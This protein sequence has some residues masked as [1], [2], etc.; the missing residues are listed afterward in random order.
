MVNLISSLG[1]VAVAVVGLI[2]LAGSLSMMDSMISSWSI[3]F[4][5]DIVAPFKKV[6]S[7]GMITISRI[8]AVVLGFGGLLFAMTDLPSIF[9]IISR[10][11]QGIVQFLPAVLLGLFWKRGNKASAIGGLA[12]GFIITGIFAFTA[13][14]YVPALAGMQGGLVGLVANFLV[15]T[16]FALL[17]KPK[18]ATVEFIASTIVEDEQISNIIEGTN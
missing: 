6:S 7:R 13:P 11:Y 5:N 17:S 15:Y 14:D 1:P 3:V 12:V 8:V 16:V 18:A 10:M 4:A 2:I 9:Q